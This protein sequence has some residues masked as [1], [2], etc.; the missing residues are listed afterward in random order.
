VLDG[1]VGQR[2][3]RC[4]DG[5]LRLLAEVRTDGAADRPRDKARAAVFD[6]IKSLYN[7]ARRHATLGNLGPLEFEKRAKLA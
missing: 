5:E 3:A 7:A 4:G 2:L 6:D 1:P